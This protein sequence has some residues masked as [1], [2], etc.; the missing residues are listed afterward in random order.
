MTPR[1]RVA[2]RMP[3]K[4][5]GVFAI[6]RALRP[7]ARW[8][9]ARSWLGGRPSMGDVAWPR[10]ED[11]VPL[12]FA[13]QIDLAELRA[14]GPYLEIPTHGA[15]AFFIGNPDDHPVRGAVRLVPSS[16]TVPPTA[17]PSDMPPLP[18]P[19]T[20]YPNVL[21]GA[22]SFPMWPLDLTAD[23][24][25]APS[26]PE[27]SYTF[28]S[29][30]R[31]FRSHLPETAYWDTALRFTAFLDY[32]R[33]QSAAQRALAQSSLDDWVAKRRT[34]LKPNFMTRLKWRF[35][36]LPDDVAATLKRYDG[37]IKERRTKIATFDKRADAFF[38]DLA[39]WTD[40]R[41]PTQRLD[42]AEKQAL[43]GFHT[44]ARTELA[45]L[46]GGLISLR[47]FADLTIR[48]FAVGTDAQ[49]ALI[50]EEERDALNNVYRGPRYGHHQIFGRGV[51]VQTEYSDHMFDLM[52]LQLS[53]DT[54]TNFYFGDMGNISFW[55]SPEDFA[56]GRFEAATVE[57]E[58]H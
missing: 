39:A 42:A 53:F 35:D 41:D 15:L 21:P 1:E 30:S 12:H 8:D 37:I 32:M 45:V 27:N 11:G 24:D 46:T 20:L 17:P 56:A 13:A 48:E 9:T 2:A 55:I 31:D 49:V 50:P 52:L 14:V 29:A 5:P 43:E 34:L 44:R 58:S 28:G 6:R 19:D 33:P 7:K 38:D 22:S 57:S 36:G 18:G 26:I 54:L 10:R 16:G 40:G 23:I 3:E 51:E 25:A 47:D 4:V